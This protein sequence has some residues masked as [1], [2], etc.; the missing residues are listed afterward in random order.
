MVFLSIS[1]LHEYL[2]GNY[3]ALPFYF[4]EFIYKYNFFLQLKAT[5]I[6]IA[7]EKV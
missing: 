7:N 3:F 5:Y 1:K 4:P 2:S 6:C